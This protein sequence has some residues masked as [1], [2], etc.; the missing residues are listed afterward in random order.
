MF[1]L[2]LLLTLRIELKK[3]SVAPVVTVLVL[4]TCQLSICGFL[5]K[6]APRV[7]TF[8]LI[9]IGPHESHQH[10]S[11]T[12]YHHAICTSDIQTSYLQNKWFALSRVL[13]YGRGPAVRD[14]TTEC[15]GYNTPQHHEYA[16]KM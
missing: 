5:Y 9:P 11:G 6:L 2:V 1:L 8:L 10:D 13:N 16:G 3:C 12:T 7:I 4:P 14:G 15:A